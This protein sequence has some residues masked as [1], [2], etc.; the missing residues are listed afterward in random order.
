VRHLPGAEKL[1]QVTRPAASLAEPIPALLSSCT[2]AT[3]GVSDKSDV[4][5]S[6][7][8]GSRVKNLAEKQPNAFGRR[9][10]RAYEL[11]AR[12]AQQIVPHDR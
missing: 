4:T 6:A 3:L 10:E 7:R 8:G 1:R 5:E 2:A 11:D 12:L 9:R